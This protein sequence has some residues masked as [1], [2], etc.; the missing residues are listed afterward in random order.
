MNSGKGTDAGHS[1]DKIDRAFQHLIDAKII[2]PIR[3]QINMS[4]HAK[5][6]DQII[7]IVRCYYFKPVQNVPNAR[8]SSLLKQIHVKTDTQCEHLRFINSF[9]HEVIDN[10][11]LDEQ[12][13]Y[14]H[15]QCAA[16]FQSCL[17][18]LT[19]NQNV[20]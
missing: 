4:R 6:K 19:L 12:R 10:L 18:E 7:S 15:K 11:W 14:L 20:S 3:T 1:T 9:Y 17:D 5:V 16:Y 2:E 13:A 8:K